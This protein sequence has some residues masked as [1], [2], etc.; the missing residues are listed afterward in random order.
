MQ[1]N[2]QSPVFS[3]P[4]AVT[5]AAVPEENAIPNAFFSNF[6]KVSS[7]TAVVGLPTLV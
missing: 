5:I 1:L 4:T 6:A 3:S 7:Y 2:K